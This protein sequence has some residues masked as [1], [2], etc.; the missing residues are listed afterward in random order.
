MDGA[1]LYSMVLSV[2]TRG[3]GH[4]LEPRAFHMATRNKFCAVMVSE[5]WY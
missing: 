1:V 4:R 2:R 5:P 3:A